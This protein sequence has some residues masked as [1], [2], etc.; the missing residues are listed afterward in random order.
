MYKKEN[1]FFFLESL[2]KLAL[3]TNICRKKRW[4]L[5]Y[6]DDVIVLTQE[7]FGYFASF[8][9]CFYPF[10]PLNQLEGK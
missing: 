8:L 2:D 6:A 7:T 9:C 5:L 10:N 1:P 3:N 4:K